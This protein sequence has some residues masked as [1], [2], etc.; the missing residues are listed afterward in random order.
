M[1]RTQPALWPVRKAGFCT[2][3][4]PLPLSVCLLPPVRPRRG[5][6]GAAPTPLGPVR[7]EM[8]GD[9]SGGF[10]SRCPAPGATRGRSLP[11]PSMAAGPSLHLPPPGEGRGEPPPV[12]WHG[13]RA[14]PATPAPPGLPAAPPRPG[15]GEEARAGGRRLHGAPGRP[16]R[17]RPFLPP[18]RLRRGSR[19]GPYVPGRER[20]EALRSGTAAAAPAPPRRQG[21]GAGEAGM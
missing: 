13:G 19:R 10:G 21:P 6:L 14:G 1:G 16:R 8:T 15:P 2:A 12:P 7:R 11:A 5:R 17:T 3:A 4:H 18:R 20:G 9:R